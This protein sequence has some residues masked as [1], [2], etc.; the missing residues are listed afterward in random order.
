MESATLENP[1]L[2][3]DL[4]DKAFLDAARK[5]DRGE[6]FHLEL[7]SAEES[8]QRAPDKTAADKTSSTDTKPE[9]TN[10]D[11]RPRDE[12]GRFKTREDGT[13]IPESER[14]PVEAVQ[15]K[16]DDG[17][18]K[19]DPD[20]KPNESAYAK[21]ER[22][23][24][25]LGK[26][27]QQVEAEKAQVRA[28]AE[29][30]DRREREIAER[31]Q[32]AEQQ[33]RQQP[34]RKQ[35]QY[36]AKDYAEFAREARAKAQ[37]L[38]QAGDLDGADEQTDLAL[39]ASE[40]AEQ[41][42]EQEATVQQQEMAQH[43]ERLWEYDLQER[44]RQEPDLANRESELSK[45]TMSLMVEYPGLFEHIPVMK[46]PDGRQMGGFS[47][48]AE[49]AKLRLQAGSASVLE[50]ENKKL[51]AEVERLNGLTSING[52]GPTGG[53]AMQTKSF[54]QM[55]EEEQDRALMAAAARLDSGR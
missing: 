49:V 19:A 38:R 16:P 48:A 17:K 47:M 6:D 24:E 3:D 7:P 31:Q 55:T 54:E 51:K 4:M 9:T 5:A 14:A 18:S 15:D 52:G 41:T 2:K 53:S 27:W 10:K 35:P 33:Q 44:V 8:E 21:A 30:L 11:E 50:Q 22:E 42:R 43:Y 37:Q 40:A 1:V 36:S 34:E 39:K 46:M 29:E 13:E 28:R 25:R 12:L 23:R 20:A 32:F 45:Q 26:S